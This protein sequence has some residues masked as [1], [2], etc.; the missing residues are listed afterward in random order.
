MLYLP[1]GLSEMDWMA[2]VMPPVVCC[3]TLGKF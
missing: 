2:L 3:M 1:S